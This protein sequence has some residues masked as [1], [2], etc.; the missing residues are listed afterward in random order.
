LT[1]A[2]VRVAVIGAGFW[3]IK[4][5][6]PALAQ[7]DDVELVAVCRLGRPELETIRREYGFGFATESYEE[8]LDAG[9][10][11]ALICG[12]NALHHTQAMAALRR[13]LH[14][15]VEKPLALK[16][17]DAWEL[18]D[19]VTRRDAHGLVPHGWH[20]K[21]FVR[22]ARELIEA[23]RIGT[24]QHAVCQMASAYRDLFEGRRGY[25][26]IALGDAIF[27]A[28][29]ETWAGAD[30]GYA[31]AQ[32]S[33]SVGML[34]WLTGLRARTVIGRIST[35]R[36]GTEI[37]DAGIVEFEDGALAAL[38]GC[39]NLPDGSRAQLDIRLFGDEGMLLLDVERERCLLKRHDGEEFEH[40]VSVG[41]GLYECR[42]AVDRFI[43]LI[44]GLEERNDSP[45]EAAARTTEILE[46]L[47]MSAREGV[48]VQIAPRT[49]EAT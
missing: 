48:P 20:Y 14:V 15:L 37:A 26:T 31:V 39:G 6:L 16:A 33:H 29:P 24:V 38:S 36:T 32:M 11:A 49:V 42:S 22:H 19:E 2:T 1:T 10:D 44:L 3:A 46:A 8:A 12:P 5:H 7:R 21:A 30:G 45:F 47:L 35:S 27:E 18:A 13:D 34:C 43:D 9:V 17:R 4:N 28:D 23:G 40:P 25:G 41:D